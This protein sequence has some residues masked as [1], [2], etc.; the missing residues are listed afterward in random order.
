MFSHTSISQRENLSAIFTSEKLE[1]LYE[2]IDTI[3]NL[4]IKNSG[5]ELN[6]V[7]ASN[8]QGDLTRNPD[9]VTHTSNGVL[10]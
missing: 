6:T 1:K 2:L 8:T 9:T 4:T 7:T 3:N 10:D 5:Y